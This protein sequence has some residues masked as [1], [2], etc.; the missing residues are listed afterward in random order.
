MRFQP[1]FRFDLFLTV[2]L[3]SV[4]SL[5]FLAVETRA[6]T[7]EE[8]FQAR[9]AAPGVFVSEG[10]DTA[11]SF[12]HASGWGDGLS[13]AGDGTYRGAQDESM[14]VSGGSSLR[15]DVPGNVGNDA[16]G[17]WRKNFGRDFGE[18][19]TFYVQF[20][21]RFD[22]AE[23]D[24]VTMYNTS[25]KQVNVHGGDSTCQQVEL[26]T[27]GMSGDGNPYLYSACG[28]T[29]MFTVGLVNFDY[30]NNNTGASHIYHQQGSSSTAG[31]NCEYG[32]KFAG[33]GNGSGCFMYQ[34]V[35]N[36]WVTY[37]YKYQIGAWGQPNSTVEAWV[38]VDGGPYVQ[39]I[40]VHNVP[41]DN[42]NPGGGNDYSMLDF[43]VYM[44]NG[45]PSHP[46]GH[47]WY[48]ELIVSTQPIAAPG[49]TAGS[50][51]TRPKN[52]RFR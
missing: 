51:P 50:P 3:I 37:Y 48:D 27:E 44:S 1:G 47:T 17:T 5:W 15:F 12:Q 34:S 14:K 23:A 32:N 45:N 6:L 22:Q 35:V 9:S 29:S 30:W 39:W 11:T 21:Q 10:F 25:W 28:G 33:N 24:I 8:D 7:P 52:L 41:L 43:N 31:Y 38:A 19:S 20:Q 49:G 46:T 26:T 40:N 16:S 2:V 18:N 42:N 13:A 36:K 4:I